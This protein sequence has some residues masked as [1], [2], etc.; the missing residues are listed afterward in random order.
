LVVDS[1]YTD[2]D[3]EAE[4]ATLSDFQK[5]EYTWE[6]IGKKKLNKKVIR[7]AAGMLERKRKE[8]GKAKA[9]YTH[10]RIKRL[11]GETKKR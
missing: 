4:F 3:C 11:G 2:Q 6:I 9:F 5:E 1:H 7:A 10:P 8:G